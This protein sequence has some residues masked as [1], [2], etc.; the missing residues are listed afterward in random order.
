MNSGYYKLSPD[1]IINDILTSSANIKKIEILGREYIIYPGVYSSNRFRTTNFLLKSIKPLIKNANV[2]DMGCGMGIVGLYALENG[3]KKVIQADINPTAVKNA[4]ANKD[5]YHI[6]SQRLEIF[7][8]DCFDA[9]PLQVFDIIIFNIPFHNESH[10]INNFL[11]YAFFDPDFISTK[12]F[13]FQAQNFSHAST[14]I[15]IAF[16]NKG[17]VKALEKL[18]SKI[19]YKWSLWKVTN[20]DQQYD[21]RL[22][23]LEFPSLEEG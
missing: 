17:D 8:S 16:S 15:I 22:Y 3:A 6:S 12:H 20:A 10:E 18:F 23:L 21:N 9:L 7:H 13:L 11:D 1:Q 19:G 4:E 5:L 14:K 2:C